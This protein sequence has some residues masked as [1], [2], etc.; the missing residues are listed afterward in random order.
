MPRVLLEKYPIP[1]LPIPSLSWCSVSLKAHWLRH[2]QQSSGYNPMLPLQGAGN[3][4]PAC[5]GSTAKKKESTLVMRGEGMNANLDIPFQPCE[6]WISDFALFRRSWRASQ[7]ERPKSWPLR[8]S[9]NWS[10]M[11]WGCVDWLSE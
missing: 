8:R 9:K 10:N 3:Y 7:E 6:F 4:D 5:W 11:T 2:L 1:L